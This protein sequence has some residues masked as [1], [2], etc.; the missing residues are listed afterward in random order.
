M[1][2][3]LQDLEGSEGEVP[4]HYEITPLH[5]AI[6]RGCVD[7]L[8]LLACAPDININAECVHGGFTA[9][10]LAM[11]LGNC[12]VIQTLLEAGADI[13]SLDSL[14]SPPIFYAAY[15]NN[16]DAVE[17]LLDTGRVDVTVRNQR[18]ESLL[19]LCTGSSTITSRLLDEPAV[20]ID[21][22]SCHGKSS[23]MIA[24]ERKHE[25]LQL[26]LDHPSRDCDYK[27]QRDCTALFTAVTASNS[28]AIDLILTRFPDINVNF[29]VGDSTRRTLFM[30]CAEAGADA[31]TAFCRL[32]GDRI[33]YAA[34]DWNGRTALTFAIADGNSTMVKLIMERT[35]GRNEPTAYTPLSEAARRGSTELICLLLE[36][37][38]EQ[39]N[40]IDDD[41]ETPLLSALVYDHPE[42]AQCFLEY[43]SCDVN[44]RRG[45]RPFAP[46]AAQLQE[47]ALTA[48]E[49]A[50][51]K[52]L[53][54][55]VAA[56]V[57]HPTLKLS[58]AD[59]E[60][61]FRWTMK[62]FD[63]GVVVV[64]IAHDAL[65][66]S[67]VRA[68]AISFETAD[69]AT[70]A[71]ILYAA[72]VV[73][74]QTGNLQA[75]TDGLQLCAQYI[76]R[77]YGICK[78]L[79]TLELSNEEFSHD[80]AVRYVGS[81]YMECMLH[82]LRGDLEEAAFQLDSALRQSSDN[83]VAAL[84]A[85]VM[86]RQEKLAEATAALKCLDIEETSP[87][88]DPE[89]LHAY[90]TGLILMEL[91]QLQ[92]AYLSFQAVTSSSTLFPEALVH[93]VSILFRAGYLEEAEKIGS[94]IKNQEHTLSHLEKN[95]LLEVLGRVEIARHVK[96][97]AVL[98]KRYEAMRDDLQTR[99]DK[100]TA[101]CTDSCLTE[102]EIIVRWDVRAAKARM[103]VLAASHSVLQELCTGPVD[104]IDFAFNLLQPDTLVP[105]TRL[106]K[107]ISFGR[108]VPASR[109]THS[110]KKAS[111]SVLL[112]HSMFEQVSYVTHRLEWLLKNVRDE[113][114]HFT[115]ALANQSRAAEAAAQ[116]RL[117]E[118]TSDHAESCIGAGSA[119]AKAVL[120]GD[121]AVQ[122]SN[123]KRELAGKLQTLASKRVELDRL[124]VTLQR[125]VVY[126][127]VYA[128]RFIL[129]YGEY[130]QFKART[131]DGAA[132][133]AAYLCQLA[134][135]LESKQPILNAEKDR[136]PLQ[137]LVRV[138]V[139][140]D[141]AFNGGDKY[142]AGYDLP[143]AEQR[144]LYRTFSLT[145]PHTTEVF[146]SHAVFRHDGVFYKFQPYAP[147]IEYA[148]NSL[149][150]LLLDE[151][152]LP[153]QLLKLEGRSGGNLGDVAYYQAS[154]QVEGYSLHQVLADP[155]LLD[156][157]EPKSFSAVFV[158]SVFVG[159]G[160]AKPDN[161]IVRFTRD[162]ETNQTKSVS[163][164]SIDNDIAFCS[165]RLRVRKLPNGKN[166]LYSDLLNILFFFPQMDSPVDESV[167][168]LVLDR[169]A[170][171]ELIVSQWL[172]DLY[173]QNQRYEALRKVGFT[174]RDLQALKLPIKLPK[175][176]A[177][178]LYRRFLLLQEILAENRSATHSTI[179]R[180]FYPAISEYYQLKRS[181]MGANAQVATMK[182]M[183]LD[184]CEDPE[185]AATLES[186]DNIKS[187]AGWSSA[188]KSKE[189]DRERYDEV[190]S[191]TVQVVATQFLETVDCQD[192]RLRNET[193]A[194]TLLAENL[195]FL[196]KLRLLNVSEQQLTWMFPGAA[197]KRGAP[198]VNSDDAAT[199]VSFQPA[200]VVKEVQIVCSEENCEILSNSAVMSNLTAMLGIRVTFDDPDEPLDAVRT[201]R[202]NI[203]N[204]VKAARTEFRDLEDTVR[205]LLVMFQEDARTPAQ[206]AAFLSRVIGIVFNSEESDVLQLDAYDDALEGDGSLLTQFSVLLLDQVALVPVA[207]ALANKGAYR[208]HSM[209]LHHLVKH[210]NVAGYEE[211]ITCI[212]KSCPEV[213]LVREY[214]AGLLP[215]DQVQQLPAS[216]NT[217]KYRLLSAMFN[218][219]RDLPAECF[220]PAPE[221]D[222]EA[223]RF[224][225]ILGA[226]ANDVEL[227]LFAAS[228]GF[229]ATAAEMSTGLMIQAKLCTEVNA[230]GNTLLHTFL[231]DDCAHKRERAVLLALGAMERQL[232]AGTITREMVD[233]ALWR[234]EN[235]EGKNVWALALD[236]KCYRLLDVLYEQWHGYEKVA[237]HSETGEHIL[238][239]SDP[240]LRM[241]TQCLYLV[242]WPVT[243]VDLQSYLY[244]A[245]ASETAL[246]RAARFEQDAANDLFTS[247]SPL[248]TH[249][250][251]SRTN[252]AGNSLLYEL[253]VTPQ[254]CY[255]QKIRVQNTAVV[256]EHLLKC[257]ANPRF[258]RRHNKEDPM[259][260]ALRNGRRELY[261]L[262]QKYELIM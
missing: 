125:C 149:N 122:R 1:G 227:L 151:I 215:A 130:S 27:E 96:T 156:L 24:I 121:H 254:H 129:E 260:V 15:F 193:A 55:V 84:R 244:K 225:H 54:D 5:A 135:A 245:R 214:G 108:T 12:E 170:A 204:P 175:I 89:H 41:G 99:L 35:G 233:D 14:G 50:V 95:L 20:D 158:S 241:V 85:L 237:I 64:L 190:F 251:N 208:A 184:S 78:M 107:L 217:V 195:Y 232:A 70:A 66:L 73:Q 40:G 167:V 133:G 46:D 83:S 155:H 111:C 98:L 246:E 62:Y 247:V 25:S 259:S 152:S 145:K 178:T 218:A 138:C 39:L 6:R 242:H 153:T 28:R 124:L 105:Q 43:P 258:T 188:S 21:E 63:I 179:L 226:F 88:T 230:R 75:A 29:D 65:L 143:S 116:A 17:A 69:P 3:V 52:K 224:P 53:S 76:P 191:E 256:I 110:A 47:T 219:C 120:Y 8:R 220:E 146:G 243:F 240:V 211:L 58:L 117:E 205:E 164:M 201:M 182:E 87:I 169:P 72:S 207:I 140:S 139:Q 10:Q 114:G 18:G 131:M 23:L 181:K 49:L 22:Y 118:L 90:I 97:S 171:P 249:M 60:K 163:L 80:I 199:T 127:T 144:V 115:D 11:L 234:Y 252:R 57:R 223:P 13:T 257:G 194:F 173:E 159:T 101:P 112:N 196:P 132:N 192:P 100:L 176:C 9:L 183:Y 180:A 7:V 161:F 253:V 126:Y 103:Q 74:A 197:S 202:N 67:D 248:L 262:M 36:Y 4:L 147:G 61:V 172:R 142:L 198:P 228:C 42:C 238:C 123:I 16:F 81:P 44:V 37:A 157:V 71:R 255:E 236:Q 31:V 79:L 209:L 91:G 134:A 19:H 93:A 229:S 86:L 30:A 212:I 168:R 104:D 34:E 106:G 206:T 128:D 216:R 136:G 261:E 250:L 38:S 235:S 77:D 162:E 221:A 102:N 45:D 203:I 94:Y 32:A 51:I 160:D 210:H 189:M 2:E 82:Y 174:D 231:T 68:M 166:K 48:L 239:R 177:V 92:R 187:K 56:V 59:K 186:K 148:V 119:A 150:L 33:D 213:L 109:R 154:P 113:A 26:M 222:P 141:A 137:E 165:G 200:S 185:I